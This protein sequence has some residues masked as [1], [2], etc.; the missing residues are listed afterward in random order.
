MKRSA[1]LFLACALTATTALADAPTRLDLDDP[2]DA[3]RGL[4]KIQCHL[5]DGKPAIYYFTGSVY[6]RRAG[7]PD[8]RL[9]DYQA[10]NLR[11]CKSFEDETKGYGYR[12]VSKEVVVYLD[13]RTGTILREWQNPWSGEGVEVVHVANDP[14]NTD[15]I[16]ANG[17]RGPFALGAEFAE[18]RGWLSFE[19]PLFYENPLGGEYQI[20]AGGVYQAIEMFVFHFD[21]SDLLDPEVTGLDDTHVSWSRVAPWLPWMRMRGRTGWVVYS[22]AGKRVRSWDALPELLRDEIAKNHEGFDE[23]PPLDDDRDN[24]TSW[25]YFKTFIDDQRARA[26]AAEEKAEA[27]NAAIRESV[28]SES[29]PE[30]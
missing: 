20:Y 26:K 30:R 16:W 8:R 28:E 6:S 15:V 17:E 12:Q 25:T 18:G 3:V 19:I 5:E 23:P 24:E 27:E 13:P 14:V 7:E 2:N 22:G 4:Q 21:E 29:E 11:A 10:M 9:F 1:A